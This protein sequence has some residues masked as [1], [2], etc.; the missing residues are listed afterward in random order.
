M[1]R[2]FPRFKEIIYTMLAN[3]QLDTKNVCFFHDSIRFCAILPIVS[4]TFYDR[5][6]LYETKSQLKFNLAWNAI[7]RNHCQQIYILLYNSDSIYE[8]I[9]FFPH[10]DLRYVVGWAGHFAAGSAKQPLRTA[11]LYTIR[12]DFIET[13]LHTTST[14]PWW[15][16]VKKDCVVQ[17]RDNFINPKL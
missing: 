4:R 5:R 9:R 11:R 8:N 15:T 7:L 17:Q 16:F 12:V 6:R 1:K 10:N 13:T 3:L 2:R 14:I